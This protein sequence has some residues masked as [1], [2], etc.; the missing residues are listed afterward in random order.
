M[1][2]WSSLPDLICL[3][4][5][6]AEISLLNVPAEHFHSYVPNLT[7]IGFYT[8]THSSPC[9]HSC[10]NLIALLPLISFPAISSQPCAYLHFLLQFQKFTLF[11]TWHPCF[12]RPAL[13]EEVGRTQAHQWLSVLGSSRTGTPPWGKVSLEPGMTMPPSRTPSHGVG[14][15]QAEQGWAQ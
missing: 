4:I 12:L 1:K 2:N 13:K 11:W 9:L 6:Q 8:Y 10:F 15:R 7:L 3:C 14:V 5:S